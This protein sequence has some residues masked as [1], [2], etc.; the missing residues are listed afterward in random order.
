MFIEQQLEA[1]GIRVIDGFVCRGSM[2]FVSASHPN[3]MNLKEPTDFVQKTM[4]ANV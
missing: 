3:A 1:K 4:S 2:L